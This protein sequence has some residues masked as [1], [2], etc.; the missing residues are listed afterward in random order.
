VSAA[1][2]PALRELS[3]EGFIVVGANGNAHV[4]GPS[5]EEVAELFDIRVLL[6][7]DCLERAALNLPDPALEDIERLRRKFRLATPIV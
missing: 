6:E 1:R 2:P 3:E 7:C 4:I 5:R